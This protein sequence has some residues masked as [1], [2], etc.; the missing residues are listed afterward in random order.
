MA[1]PTLWLGSGDSSFDGELQK[2]K[3]KLAKGQVKEMYGHKKRVGCVAWNHTGEKLA[4][5]SMDATVRI[6]ASVER[7]QTKD[8]IIELRGHN[9]VVNVVCWNPQDTEQLATTSHD[10]TIRLW[11]VRSGK[12]TLELDAKGKGSHLAWSPDGYTIA[13]GSKSAGDTN[14]Q[15]D[16]LQHIDTRKNKVTKIIKFHYPINQM[17]WNRAGSTFFLT[18]SSGCIELWNWP[19]FKFVRTVTADTVPLLSLAMSPD[20]QTFVVGSESTLSLWD[21]N[22][23]VCLKSF[24]NFN[25]PIKTISLSHDGQY[26]AAGS[27]DTFIDITHVG[28]G[29]SVYTLQTDAATNGVA[30]HP[31][32]LLLAYCGNDQDRYSRDL[33]TVKIF[34]VNGTES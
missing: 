7:K 22:E 26:I 24:G 2:A 29:E 11:D 18:T 3:K 12:C 33:C 17:S 8:A 9:T 31:S 25:S 16:L 6:W 32:K 10:Q 30:W 5:G 23:L 1:E 34:G 21:S 4:S 13:H 14:Q 19:E 20:N 27:D 15:L 28:S